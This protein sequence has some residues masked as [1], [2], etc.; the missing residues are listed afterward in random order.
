MTLTPDYI[1]GFLAGVLAGIGFL[2]FAD[3]FTEWQAKRRYSRK[4]RKP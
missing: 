3:C 2:C 4:E 1:Q